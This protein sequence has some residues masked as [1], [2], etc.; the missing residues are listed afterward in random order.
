MLKTVH[1]YISNNIEEIKK[2]PELREKVFNKARQW[3][4][5]AELYYNSDDMA[6]VDFFHK[7]GELGFEE[8]LEV[9]LT[10]CEESILMA[11]THNINNPQGIPI[12]SSD[13][14]SGELNTISTMMREFDAEI[15][16][17]KTGGKPV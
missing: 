15:V 7:M 6:V 17:I 2:T 16:D 9:L 12:I 3:I 8:G 11:S 5:L 14:K 1:D 4:S 13:Q 10:S